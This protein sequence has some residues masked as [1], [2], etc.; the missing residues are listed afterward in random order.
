MFVCL[1]SM[2]TLSLP[3]GTASAAATSVDPFLALLSQM[4]H[5]T[6]RHAAAEAAAAA[7]GAAA[8]S[9]EA[10]MEDEPKPD[11]EANAQ[12]KAIAASPSA[13]APRD[14]SYLDAHIRSYQRRIED[15]LAYL[16][17]YRFGRG[18]S[19]PATAAIASLQRGPH[20]LQRDV[21]S[22][23]SEWATWRLLS[24]LRKSDETEAN[25]A[26]PP[27]MHE[28][29]S[30]QIIADRLVHTPLHPLTRALHI[31]NWLEELQVFLLRIESTGEV[32]W[33]RSLRKLQKATV[34]DTQRDWIDPDVELRLKKAGTV[35]AQ[36]HV[37]DPQDA[38]EE[39]RM[40]EYVWSLMRA[41]RM[42]EAIE[43]C[44]T[45]NQAWRA[46]SLSG[47]ERWHDAGET[48]PD[49]SVFRVGN[50]HRLLWRHTCRALSSA[51]GV[52]AVESSIYGLLGGDLS[53]A[54]KYSGQHKYEEALYCYLRCMVD[55]EVEDFMRSEGKADADAAVVP[56]SAQ[57]HLVARSLSAV[58]T[59]LES[60]LNALVAQSVRNTAKFNP[61]TRLQKW[62]MLGE[63]EQAEQEMVR[64]IQLH[65][66][67]ANQ[68]QQLQQ[69]S[70]QL[71]DQTAQTVNWTYLFFAFHV[72]LYLHPRAPHAEPLNGA[73]VYL[74]QALLGY[75]ESQPA[76][77][78]LVAS[79]AQYLAPW[80][81][82][83]MYVRF[84]HRIPSLAA[85]QALLA[86]FAQY[87][88]DQRLEVT[89]KLVS[90]ILM[91]EEN[92]ATTAT[93]QQ[94]RRAIAAGGA[95]DAAG[96]AALSGGALGS[97]VA[98]LLASASSGITA[99]DLAKISALDCFDLSAPSISLSVVESA[100][101]QVT[102]LYRAF[103]RAEKYAAAKRFTEHLQN[104]KWDHAIFAAIQQAQ[105]KAINRQAT[106]ARQ[107]LQQDRGRACVRIC[108]HCLVFVL[109]V[110]S[111]SAS[112]HAL[113]REYSHWK[114]Y[115]RCLHWYDAWLTHQS[116]KPRAPVFNPNAYA[117][118]ALA[119]REYVAFARRWESHEK[120]RAE[121][122]SNDRETVKECVTSFSE[123]LQLEGGWMTPTP[124]ITAGS[125]GA[126]QSGG[127]SSS[128][129]SDAELSSLR[130]HLIPRLT[131]MLLQICRESGQEE[132]ALGVA[133]LIAAPMHNLQACFSPDQMRACIMQ[134]RAAYINV[135]LKSQRSTHDNDDRVQA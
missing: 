99:S 83:S 31:L 51:A 4:A 105:Q 91:D 119:Q 92:E 63:T 36:S 121:W 70:Q 8:E 78:A 85:R 88:P 106:H 132:I 18:G 37:L 108:T 94:G 11:S 15:V 87:C 20:E 68:P 61:Y 113:D 120:D 74:C 116:E 127:S 124:V 1:Q 89:N 43:L 125:D 107:A 111:V 50:P 46:A 13:S 66:K 25:Q 10:T 131:S 62:L 93:E 48:Q 34:G 2:S 72:Y 22:L 30:Q 73:G 114:L 24:E 69:S 57:A 75:L 19:S 77:H 55:E 100:L 33:R 65:Y 112:W 129:Q 71:S 76:Q 23:E 128:P 28:R 40:L 101:A 86:S 16:Q 42:P 103:V 82:V 35:H 52:S 44:R 130:V 26:V 98:N 117:S 60:P 90:N 14:L 123:L 21:S 126:A 7:N 84:L 47:G 118:S 53:S 95:I 45:Y 79:Y 59:A 41:G 9:K 104:K 135:H 67:P 6:I 64:T 110:C 17:E 58:L 5:S 12:A 3:A 115:M 109:C 80:A 54:L 27:S 56:K 122:A 49:G 29:Y 133:D 39:Q 97:G 81:R 102:Q 134:F 38:E 32:P 96:L